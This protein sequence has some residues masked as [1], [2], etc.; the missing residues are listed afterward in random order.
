LP[1][2]GDEKVGNQ[3]TNNGFFEIIPIG[4]RQQFLWQVI[5]MV[6]TDVHSCLILDIRKK[7]NGRNVYLDQTKLTHFVGRVSNEGNGFAGQIEMDRGG[8]KGI[9]RIENPG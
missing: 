3:S 8:H 2:V 7:T 4:L 5:S 6:E 1:K 9:G